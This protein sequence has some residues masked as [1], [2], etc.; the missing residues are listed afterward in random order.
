[1]DPI[2]CVGR[3]ILYIDECVLSIRKQEMVFTTKGN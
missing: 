3:L 1:M 2:S